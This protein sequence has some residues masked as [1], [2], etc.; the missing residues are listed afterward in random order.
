MNNPMDNRSPPSS[1][2]P[3]AGETHAYPQPRIFPHYLLTRVDDST[4]VQDST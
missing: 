2:R 3:R 4:T 1:S